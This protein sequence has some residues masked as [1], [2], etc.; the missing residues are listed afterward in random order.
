[1]PTAAPPLLPLFRSK[2]QARLL[3]DLYLRPSRRQPLSELARALELSHSTVSREAERLEQAGLLRSELVGKQRLLFANEA[4]PFYPALHQLLLRAFG[5]LPLAEQTLARLRG[6]EKAYLYGSWAARYLGE[7]GEAPN[8]LD[9]LVV[10]TPDR[11]ALA[12]LTNEL[13]ERLAVDVNPTVVPAADW[14]T[15]TSGF[16]RSLAEGPLVELHLHQ[17]GESP[18]GGG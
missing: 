6:V 3:A 14:Q 17:P 15:Q 12:K 11:R 13:A 8:D 2:A 5:P 16:L 4:S 10:G 7:S 9:L 1:M 18:D